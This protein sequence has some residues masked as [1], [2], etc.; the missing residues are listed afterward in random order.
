MMTSGRV[1]AKPW[2]I[3]CP[4]CRRAPRARP[5]HRAVLGS[6]D[7]RPGVYQLYLRGE[8]VYVGKADNFLPGRPSEEAVRTTQYHSP[9]FRSPACA[10]MRTSQPW[11]PEWLL[12]SHHKDWGGNGFCNKDPSRQRENKVL[13]KNHFDAI[14]SIAPGR[15]VEDLEPGPIVL[16]TLLKALKNRFPVF[17]GMP[18]RH[19]RSRPSWLCRRA[20]CPPMGRRPAGLPRHRAE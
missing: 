15:P 20:V 1:S 9:T 5:A 19:V 7:E 8:F 18:S 12:V 11:A 17:S 4:R 10:S 16:S 13:K 6:L 3:S 2:V 14:F